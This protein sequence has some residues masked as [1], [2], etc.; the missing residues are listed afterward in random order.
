MN[1]R[2][3]MKFLSLTFLMLFISKLRFPKKEVLL[4]ICSFSK[5]FFFCPIKR[6]YNIISF[7]LVVTVIKYIYLLENSKPKKKF[8]KM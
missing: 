1:Y 5:N 7:I 3:K 6:A 2:I 4:F 8:I